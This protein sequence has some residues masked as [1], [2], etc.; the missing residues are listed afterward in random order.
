MLK[1][2]SLCLGLL[3]CLI[4]VFSYCN[5]FLSKFNLREY[6]L[7]YDKHKK[8]LNLSP[9]I[10]DSN[11]K[12][13][14]WENKLI[15]IPKKL[16]IPKLKYIYLFDPNQLQEVLSTANENLKNNAD[17]IIENYQANLGLIKE[18]Y[19]HFEN[20]IN[21]GCYPSTKEDNCNIIIRRTFF[22]ASRM[23]IWVHSLLS[24]SKANLRVSLNRLINLLNFQSRIDHSLEGLAS[25]SRQRFFTLRMSLF[26]I[27]LTED[28]EI[29]KIILDEIEK[30]EVEDIQI[31]RT[32]ELELIHNS[33][34][35]IFLSNSIKDNTFMDSLPFIN[36]AAEAGLESNKK[37]FE[38]RTKIL[39]YSGTIYYLFNL[40]DTIEGLFKI[41][42]AKIKDI[43]IMTL[44]INDP[45]DFKFKTQVIKQLNPEY[46][47]KRKFFNP[48]GRK[49]L[50]KGLAQDKLYQKI[51]S[52]VESNDHL[53]DTV[54]KLKT[55]PISEI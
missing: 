47:L 34:P 23:E 12:W 4:F 36:L 38:T 29:K 52:R 49:R 11:K 26:I 48:I 14:K 18:A 35:Y 39:V 27:G 46:N 5:F 54:L 8:Y 20:K 33:L 19:T 3:C 28:M 15:N 22:N 25:L 2:K 45:I 44:K 41:Y 21:Y 7:L 1:I 40:Q 6:N 16:N 13:I 24:I 55:I 51:L 32:L 30:M 37:Y 53:K 50:V 17:E 31:E 43:E 9:V 10:L 42:E